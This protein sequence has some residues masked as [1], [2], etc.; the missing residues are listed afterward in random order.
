MKS[1][2]KFT[3]NICIK[4]YKSQQ[5]L[6]NHNRRFHTT[7][8][9]KVIIQSSNSHHLGINKSPLNNK[10]GKHKCIYCNKTGSAILTKTES[11]FSSTE[12]LYFLEF[13][14]IGFEIA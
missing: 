12:N 1:E 11:F 5:S 6:C 3:C 7:S 9:Q 10:E 8:N 2:K 13:V 4:N 14:E